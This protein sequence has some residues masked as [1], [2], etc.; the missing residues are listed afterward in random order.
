MTCLLCLVVPGSKPNVLWRMY[1]SQT[2]V[3][4]GENK[5]CLPA[6]VVLT[7]QPDTELGFESAVKEVS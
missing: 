1:F 5:V 2:A 7:S 4:G 3:A 6:N